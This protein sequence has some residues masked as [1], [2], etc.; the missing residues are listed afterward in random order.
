MPFFKKKKKEE[1]TF[2]E[3]PD[4]PKESTLDFPPYSSKEF[5]KLEDIKNAVKPLM[6]PKEFPKLDSIPKLTETM[7]Y[8]PKEP[9]AF[10]P[11][12]NESQLD[13]PLRKKLVMQQNWQPQQPMRELRQLP[14]MP[15]QITT[16]PRYERMEAMQ[17]RYS[18]PSGSKPLFVQIDEYSKII[19]TVNSLKFSLS[20]AE[21]IL[22]NIKQLKEKEN[23]ELAR[24]DEH[25]NRLK[26]KLLMIDKRLFN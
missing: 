14:Q 12:Q 13:I 19:E 8:E 22:G 11:I 10:A 4:L 21:R 5:P 26:D 7:T 18:Q 16:Q 3:F 23:D 1:V 6:L 24:W 15:R 2:P 25:L 20:E 17:P 9:A